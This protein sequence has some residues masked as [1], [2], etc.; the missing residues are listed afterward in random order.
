MRWRKGQG[1]SIDIEPN[2]RRNVFWR[3][4]K[5]LRHPLRWMWKS[6]V[7]H[8]WSMDNGYLDGVKG[9]GKNNY[10]V[11]CANFDGFYFIMVTHIKQ[12]MHYN[13]ENVKDVHTINDVF[14]LFN[15]KFILSLDSHV[16]D[17][18]FK[19]WLGDLIFKWCLQM[20]QA[21]RE[22]CGVTRHVIK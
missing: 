6:K 13:V 17:L 5:G 20:Q 7:V 9:I 19:F 8:L 12:E 22:Y 4:K 11:F 2:A 21:W 16:F 3:W 1:E 18:L 15:Y 14:D 10:D